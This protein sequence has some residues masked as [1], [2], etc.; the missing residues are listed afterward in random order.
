[1]VPQLLSMIDKHGLSWNVWLER[2]RELAY[3][4]RVRRLRGQHCELLIKRADMVVYIREEEF[5]AAEAAAS[6]GFSAAQKRTQDILRPGGPWWKD[7]L[8]N[9]CS[10]DPDGCS[11]TMWISSATLS[12]RSVAGIILELL[13][14]QSA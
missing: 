3:I 10:L 6:S 11:L 4:F 5:R 9:V 13:S 2:Y 8:P 12:R 14:P 1:M 7:L